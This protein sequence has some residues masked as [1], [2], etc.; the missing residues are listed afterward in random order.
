MDDIEWLNEILAEANIPPIRINP[1]TER[2]SEDNLWSDVQF[3]SSLMG[4]A[5]FTKVIN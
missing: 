3:L 5:A 1:E 2:V 4:R